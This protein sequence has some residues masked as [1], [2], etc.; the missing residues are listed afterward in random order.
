MDS[1]GPADYWMWSICWRPNSVA[2]ILRRHVTYYGTIMFPP[3]DHFYCFR[4]PLTMDW[5]TQNLLKTVYNGFMSLSYFA[6][7]LLIELQATGGHC[8][9]IIHNS[10]KFPHHQHFQC[11]FDKTKS[12]I[13]HRSGWQFAAK[14]ILSAMFAS[15]LHRH[16]ILLESWLHELKSR[17]VACVSVPYHGRFITLS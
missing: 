8:A 2:A 7:G 17:S 4:M 12:N 1:N 15:A 14:A 10:H 5:L 6:N 13:G 9:L 3:H 16:R 11:T